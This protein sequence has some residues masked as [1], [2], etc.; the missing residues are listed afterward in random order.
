LVAV[1]V[2]VAWLSLVSLFHLHYDP[3]LPFVPP[4]QPFGAAFGRGLA[5]AMWNYA[6][7]EQLSSM[8]GEMKNPQ[9]TFVRILAWN[10][11]MNILTYI[12][13]TTLALAVLG[14]WQEWRTDYIVTASRLIGGPLLGAA[15]LIAAMIG[16]LSL[17]NSTILY[18]T[19][20]P[21]TM[22][23]DGYL[24]AWLGKIHPRFGTPVRA[25]ALSALV[26]CVLAK[27]PVED[28]VNIYIWTRIATTLLTLFAAW[29]MRR[30]LPNA[31]RSFL[32]PGGAAG[33]AYILIFP[34]ILCAV[35]VYYSEPLVLHWAPL[36]LASG[37][38]VYA[39][40]RW[41]FHMN[42]TPAG[43]E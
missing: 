12:L 24:P 5:L 23:Q 3:T 7:Y 25:I 42:P 10:T 39:V 13:P 26:Y 33:I 15:M 40:L 6:G 9:K 32:I 27:Y 30:K 43:P 19:R 4:G 18:T 1:F 37:P 8:T 2:P 29:R 38:I 17:S 36:L 31:P 28:M 34:T 14:N 22:A 35:K 20:I 21:A 41:G 11:P 16:T